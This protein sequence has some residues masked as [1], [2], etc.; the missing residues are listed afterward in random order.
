MDVRS[1]QRPMKEQYC[2]VMQ[3]LLRPPAIKTEWS[4]PELHCPALTAGRAGVDSSVASGDSR[5]LL[6]VSAINWAWPA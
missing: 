4:R 2:V 5:A 3:I 1:L 6:R